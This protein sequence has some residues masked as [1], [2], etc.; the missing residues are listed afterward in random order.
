MKDGRVRPISDPRQTHVRNPGNRL[1]TFQP[2][3]P[4]LLHHSERRLM[5]FTLPP[6]HK[7]ACVALENAGVDPTLRNPLNLGGDL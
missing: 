1:S 2:L 7:F 3:R 6:N 4:Q 5:P